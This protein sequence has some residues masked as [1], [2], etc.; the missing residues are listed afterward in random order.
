MMKK[1]TVIKLNKISQILEGT[2]FK[3]NHMCV[4]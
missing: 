3:I 4:G 2:G 1:K